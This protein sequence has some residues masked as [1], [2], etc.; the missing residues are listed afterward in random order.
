[1]GCFLEEDSYRT[2]HQRLEQFKQR[3]IPHNPD[4]PVI[5]HREDIVNCRKCFWRLREPAK[6][7]AFDADLLGLVAHTDFRMVAVVIDKQA[8]RERY[9]NPAHP[10]HLALGY[11][12]QRYCGYLNH[13]QCQ[14]DVMAESRGGKEDRLL[15]DS[16]QWVYERGVF[17]Q[18]APFFQKALTS[19]E[20]KVKSKKANTAG[21]QLADLLV[22][23]VRQ[24][25]LRE[26][27]RIA[28][29]PSPFVRDLLTILDGKFN[30]HLYDGRIWGY[31][32]VFSPEK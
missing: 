19:R 13:V 21:L 4:D 12:L 32:K 10:Y 14:G 20:L 30:R 31:G 11:M 29:A 9:A 8:H 3:H 16:Y 26:K 23:P 6:Q 7:S 15:K 2:F 1:L 24:A 22:H 27:G 28:D 5:L 18:R 25:I 17:M